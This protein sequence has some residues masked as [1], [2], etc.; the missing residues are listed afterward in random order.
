MPYRIFITEDD[1]VTALYIKYALEKQGYLVEGI[2][3]DAETAID[4]IRKTNPDLILMDISLPGKIDGVKAAEIIKTERNI[5][6]IYATATSDN[7][8]VQ[9]VLATDPN[10]YVLKPIVPVQLYTTIET[11]MHR[12]NLEN[13][14]TDL[15]EKLETKVEERTQ[16]LAQNNKLLEAEIDRRKTVEQNLKT[17]LAKEKE[18]NELKTRIVSIV[19]HEF[20]TPLTTILSSAELVE[21]HLKKQTPIEK[22]FHHTATIIRSVK[23]LTTILNDTLFISK[24]ETNNFKVE[25]TNCSVQKIV[26]DIWKDLKIA[27]AKNH[28]M[29]LNVSENFPEK[30]FQDEKLLK[31]AIQNLL[32]NAVKYSPKKETIFVSLSFLNNEVIVSVKDEGM[33]IPKKDFG[34]LFE[35]FHR[36][37]NVENIEGTGVGLM[38]VRRSMNVIGGSVRFRSEEG[39]GTEFILNFPPQYKSEL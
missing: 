21:Y 34:L 11:A 22:L 7:E 12:Y 26:E 1:K 6:V 39:K 8:T 32:T 37:S 25:P 30:C 36:A 5:P 29:Q 24:T 15:N 38:I 20:K 18:L 3:N 31:Q 2:A 9:R 4:Q 19:S 27:F 35:M 23:N 13:E 17:A 14:L 28:E 33:G 10:G 16:E